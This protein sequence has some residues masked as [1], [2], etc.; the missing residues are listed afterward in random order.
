MDKEKE[1]KKYRKYNKIVSLPDEIKKELDIM[2]SDTSNTYMEISD[3][4]K[5]KGF[6]ISKSTVG[7][8]ALETHKLSTKLL[9]ARTQV[10]EL[11]KLAKESNDSENITEGA[12][13]IATVKLTE[14]IAYLDEE[15]EDMDASD[16]IKLITS[17]SRTK[18]YKDKI[19]AKLKSEYEEAYNN[20]KTA[21]SEE[22]KSY[23]DILDKLMKITDN[24]M[25]KL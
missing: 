24:T 16:A 4:L 15:I 9:E 11:I 8:Y 22:L 1:Y 5:D 18:A 3:W 13:Q 17:I 19:Y 23:P 10:N 20:F 6:D 21:I 25:S 2:L 12:M 14:K 7:R